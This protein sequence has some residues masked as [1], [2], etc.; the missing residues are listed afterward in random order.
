MNKLSKR[1][2][3]K[4]PEDIKVLY[5]IKKKIIVFKGIYQQKAV[6]LK[7]K[8]YL[9]TLKKY[10]QVTKIPFSKMSSNK[11]KTLKSIQGTTISLIK[12]IMLEI[13]VVSC[14]KL[15]FIGVGYRAFPIEIFNTQLLHFKLGYSHQIYFKVP[16][17]LKI[18]C[19][20]STNLLIFGNSYQSVNQISAIIRSYKIPELYKGKGILYENEK[21]AIK[22]GKKT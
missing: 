14:N 18:S 1:Y 20:K 13:S 21:I 4:I 5:C 2:I 12:Q 8:L 17:N 19:I 3:I 15:K 11:K 7:T 22:E 6:V 16:N 9:S 10:I